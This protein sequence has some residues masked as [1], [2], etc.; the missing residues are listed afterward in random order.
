MIIPILRG[1]STLQVP[2]AVSSWGP[3]QRAISLASANAFPATSWLI[4]DVREGS[5]GETPR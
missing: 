3:R 2:A 4:S 5:L 1:T